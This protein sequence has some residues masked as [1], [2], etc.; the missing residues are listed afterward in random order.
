ML[1][2][3]LLLRRWPHHHRL[4]LVNHTIPSTAFLPPRNLR[5][6]PPQW[7][8]PH[9]FLV[10]L[11]PAKMMTTGLSSILIMKSPLMKKVLGLEALDILHLSY[12]GP[13]DH[14]DHSL[15]VLALPLRPQLQPAGLHRLHP[16]LQW[17]VLE[18][19]RHLRPRCRAP[20]HLH[21]LQCR[22]LDLLLH[23][24]CRE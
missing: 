2:L 24:Q 13:W 23:H 12:L 17:Q 4:Q 11:A 7:L 1:L 14:H 22:A 15:L 3:L 6:L 9:L 19:H 20:V 21:L 18:H 5:P 8:L 10:P 16:P